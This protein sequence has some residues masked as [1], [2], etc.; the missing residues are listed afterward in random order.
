M[1]TGSAV[2][3]T[4]SPLI[5]QSVSKLTF[6]FLLRLPNI[7]SQ[8]GPGSLLATQLA[9]WL[10]SADSMPVQKRTFVGA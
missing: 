8:L 7:R 1:K 6:G 2:S 3:R 10:Q 4:T 5:E 9:G